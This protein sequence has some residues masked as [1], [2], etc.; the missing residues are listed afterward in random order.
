MKSWFHQLG[1]RTLLVASPWLASSCDPPVEY[2]KDTQ[3]LIVVSV[4]GVQTGTQSLKV[5]SALNGK[6]DPNGLDITDNTSKFAI[7]LPNQ[8][9]SYGQLKIDGFAMDTNKCYLANGQVTEQITA[10]KT[11]YELELTLLPQASPKC[12]LTVTVTGSGTV[13]STPA[14]ISC[15]AGQT[16]CSY[17]FPFGTDVVLN[18]PVSHAAYPVWLSGCTAATTYY[19]PTCTAKVQKGGTAAT[20]DFVA[21]NCSPDGWC[22]YHPL[23]TVQSLADVWG[24]GAKDIWYVGNSGTIQRSTG[25]A[26]APSPNPF[27]TLSLTAIKGSGPNNLYALSNSGGTPGIARWDGSKWTALPSWPGFPNI[28][29]RGL[30]VLSNGDAIVTGY[31]FIGAGSPFAA[32]WNGT[33]WMTMTT[34]VTA[35]E[36]LNKVWGTSDTDLWAGGNTGIWRWDGTKWSKDPS[37]PIQNKNIQHVFG[38]SKTDVWAASSNELFHYDGTAW[39]L[40]APDNGVTPSSISNL[41]GGAGPE[42]WL[43]T[44]SANG[45]FYR[46]AGGACSPKCWTQVDVPG[47]NA[48]FRSVWGAAN[49]DLWAVGNSGLV[50]HYD[51]QTWARTPYARAPLTTGTLSASYGVANN[52]SS[53]LQIFGPVDTA[54][55]TDNNNIVP[56]TG[57][58]TTSQSAYAAYGLSQNEIMVVGSGGMIV[59]W[60]GTSW[61]TVVSGTTNSLNGVYINNSPRFYYVV[62]SSGY[63]A[64]ADASLAFMPQTKNVPPAPNPN[65]TF[66]TFYAVGGSSY[67]NLFATSYS[68]VIYRTTDGATWNQ[69]LPIPNTEQYNV[70][71]QHPSTGRVYIG[72]SN[73]SLIYYTGA[74][75]TLL[76]TGTTALFLSMWGMSGSPQMWIGGT[77]GTIL[78]FDGTNFTA[79]KTGTTATIRT[80]WGNN[81][82]DVWAAGDAGTILRWKM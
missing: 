25:G 41:G 15:G 7:Q 68:G 77:N 58:S 74:P 19:A 76:N 53:A 79:Q 71:Y 10:D 1:V 33:A 81:L 21:R 30:F 13:T 43:T 72:G 47:I 59:R 66:Q 78:K 20:V 82:T 23:G 52:Q 24:S 75:W 27:G 64:R 36:L 12:S 40:A 37:A 46:Y 61:K 8:Q 9:S 32:R 11:Y 65:T 51:G 4:K 14:G 48:T 34:G 42:V 29:A 55:N 45:R 3:I 26:F 70:V 60:D 22:Q 28:D 18:G 38:T 5:T 57:Y 67:T 50:A 49:N 63:I 44:S 54:L 17:D 6:V 39:T 2:I 31:S 62:G 73:G 16:T 80:V 56:A 69:V 35:N